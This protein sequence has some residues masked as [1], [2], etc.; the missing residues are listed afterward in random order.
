[1]AVSF[2]FSQSSYCVTKDT[3]GNL[4]IIFAAVPA[5]LGVA[6]EPTLYKQGRSKP[7]DH[8]ADQVLPV[9]CLGMI[10]R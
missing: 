9:A 4:G 3:P 10:R 2:W 1:M 7:L 8:R 5:A 6:E